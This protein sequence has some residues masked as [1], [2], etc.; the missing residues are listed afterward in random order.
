MPKKSWRDSCCLVSDNQEDLEKAIR[1]KDAK[2]GKYY[3]VL[4]CLYEEEGIKTF[5]VDVFYIIVVTAKRRFRGNL[6]LV[7]QE[8]HQKDGSIKDGCLESDDRILVDL[9]EKEL[10]DF[11]NQ[12]AINAMY[13][14]EDY[15]N[16]YP[17]PAVKRA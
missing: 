15:I 3:R 8:L 11:T 1:L 5:I 7:V 17:R 2:V 16:M 13:K 9:T 10:I 6:Q 12:A 14:V 4:R